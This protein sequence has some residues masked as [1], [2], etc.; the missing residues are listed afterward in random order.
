MS[1]SEPF[2]SSF[3][4]FREQAK[5]KQ[6]LRLMERFC[7]ISHFLLRV[8]VL[9]QFGSLSRAPLRLLRLQILPELV[10]CDSLARAGDPWDVDV[11][12]R[13][14][15]RHVTLQVFH[16]AIDLRALL[17]LAMPEAEVARFRIYRES[18]PGKRELIMMGHAQ[19]NDQ[20]A[21]GVHS[22]AMRAKVLGF[23]FRMEDETLK[24]IPEENVSSPAPKHPEL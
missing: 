4:A 17:F 18:E 23:R 1:S 11:Q 12:E 24:A 20:S 22:L 16:D 15:R 13:I 19:R 3:E 21:R 6:G 10:E 7:D 9:L 14:A 5:A 8:R 2:D